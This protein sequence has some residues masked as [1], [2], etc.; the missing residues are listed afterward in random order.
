MHKVLVERG[1]E[2][3]RPGIEAKAVVAPGVVHK[4]VDAAPFDAGGGDGADAIL[5]LR[6]VGLY[7]A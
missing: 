7:P 3:L 5:I 4:A 6:Q 1:A 2:G